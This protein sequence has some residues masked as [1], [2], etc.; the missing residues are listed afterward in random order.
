MTGFTQFGM[1]NSFGVFQAYYE[2]GP[3]A[4]YSPSTISWI[5]SMQMFLMFFG[6]LFV[7]RIFDRHGPHVLMAP[8]TVCLVLSLMLTSVCKEYYQFLLAQ[9]V[10]FGIG[11][12]LLFHPSVAAPGQWF[13]HRRALAMGF[14]SLGSGLGGVV[15]P[16][17][18]RRLVV[19]I[20]FP[21]T[22]R[23]LG[24]ISLGVC[25]ASTACVRTR[26]P[27][28]EPVPWAT[29]LTPLREAPFVFLTIG[30]C[31][32]MWGMYMPFTFLATNAVRLGASEDLA[33]YTLALL[34]AGSLGGRVVSMLGDK[35]GRFNTMAVSAVLTGIVLLAFWIP[36]S[37]VRMI[38][39]F[40]VVYGFVSG[41]LISIVFACVQQVGTAKD[42]GRKVG[43]MWAIASFF[44]L[45]GPPINGA[46]IAKADGATGYRYAGVFSGVVVLVS[47]LFTLASKLKQDKRLF[48]VV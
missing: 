5:G 24:F 47:T 12:T 2:T 11:S 10:L 28:K 9:G 48:A 26:L 27:R 41:I 31:L 17:V 19:E 46:F 38:L 42:V 23:A 18:V 25:V 36:L 35:F 8:G 22:M 39:A 30:A 3:L 34:N 32:V 29:V 40:A 6:G 16:I 33:F 7:G 1:S 4:A 45:S 13:L 21:W 43:L 14:A 15:W 44:S 37:S 20:G